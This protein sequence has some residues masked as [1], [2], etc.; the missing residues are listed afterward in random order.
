METLRQTLADGDAL[1]DDG[2]AHMVGQ[3]LGMEQYNTIRYD[4]IQ[5]NTIQYNTIQYNIPLFWPGIYAVY[6]Q[7]NNI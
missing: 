6:I 5:Y 3:N 2:V 4:T 1:R 7:S